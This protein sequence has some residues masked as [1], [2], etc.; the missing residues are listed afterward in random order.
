MAGR[1]R[2]RL[3][4]VQVDF[5]VVVTAVAAAG[6]DGRRGAVHSV[7]VCMCVRVWWRLHADDG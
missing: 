2:G 4:A 3:G 6:R 5:A 1:R 7:C